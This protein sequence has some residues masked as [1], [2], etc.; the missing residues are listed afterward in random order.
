MN[1]VA[2]HAILVSLWHEYKQVI[3]DVELG[4][5]LEELDTSAVPMVYT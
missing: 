3:N 1:F 4:Y 5:I 2:N